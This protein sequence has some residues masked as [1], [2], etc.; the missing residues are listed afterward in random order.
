MDALGNRLSVVILTF[1]RRDELRRTLERMSMLPEQ[2]PIIIVD[3]ASTDGTAQ[4]VRADFRQ[5]TLLASPTNVGGAA[6]NLGVQQARTPYVAFCDD[7]SWWAPGSLTAA[8]DL[9]DAYPS[10][11]AACAR[12]LLGP[13]AREDPICCMMAASPLPAAGLPGPALLGFVACAAVFR[14]QAYLDAGGYE[15]RFFVGGE[16]TLLT[17]DLVSAG[18]YLVYAPQLLVHH[19]PS[20]QRDRKDR[21]RIVARNAIWVAWLRLPALTALRETWRMLR[22]A[23]RHGVLAAA[24]RS[25]LRELPWLA[26]TRRVVSPRVH[27]WYRMLNP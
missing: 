6:R 5:V 4:M 12:I 16:E 18:W 10:I 8:A 9:L 26:S 21:H 2:P 13:E 23:A 14:R 19:Y 22:Y 3:N 1:N 25:V 24:V 15:Q 20:P 27:A 17:L 7:D 11:A